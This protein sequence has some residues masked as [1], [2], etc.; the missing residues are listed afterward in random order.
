[1]QVSP[2]AQFGSIYQG[3][4]R[5][6]SITLSMVRRRHWCSTPTTIREPSI[7]RR[8]RPRTPPRASIATSFTCSSVPPATSAQPR[9]S[10][11]PCDLRY[12][13]D[14]RPQP[15]SPMTHEVELDLRAAVKPPQQLLPRGYYDQRAV[16]PRRLADYHAC[17]V[18]IARNA[19][20]GAGS[21][22]RKSNPFPLRLRVGA[23]N[24]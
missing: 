14:F 12:D 8:R 5:I 2:S 6:N 23:G 16:G 9:K 24:F 21:I 4:V 18:G 22:N 1:M 3:A 13:G 17:R 7:S 20:R 10:H 15:V 11:R 19:D